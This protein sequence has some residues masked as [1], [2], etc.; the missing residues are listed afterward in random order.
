MTCSHLDKDRS[1][2]S[3]DRV[4]TPGVPV[5]GSMPSLPNRAG[6]VHCSE[7]KHYPVAAPGLISISFNKAI[8]LSHEVLPVI[9]R[10]DR[11][12][13]AE[14]SHCHMLGMLVN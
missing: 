13:H 10:V 14:F 5:P 9:T 7:G 8:K 2:C 12:S 3:F 11:L 6:T 4:A 1:G